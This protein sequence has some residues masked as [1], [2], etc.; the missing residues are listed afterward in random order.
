M[1]TTNQSIQKLTTLPKSKEEI[2]AF[3]NQVK[4]ALINGDVNPLE[5]LRFFKAMEKTHEAV[6]P[7]LD[8]NA[9][10]EAEK[11]PARQPI[12]MSGVKFELAEF[13]TRYDYSVCNDQQYDLLKS[14]LDL[15]SAKLKDREKFLQAL[16]EP[17]DMVDEGTG[18]VIK[19][20]PPVKKSTTG[21]RTTFM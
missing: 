21:L 12:E 17:F 3:A 8:Q 11:F 14:E 20:N 15:V 10:K 1:E 18:E 16:K 9:V 13:G 19:I 4:E 5:V 2:G 6:K 7:V